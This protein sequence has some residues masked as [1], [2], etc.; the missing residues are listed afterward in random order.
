[1][2][3]KKN[4]DFKKENSIQIIDN[5]R[6]RK[7]PY[8]NA[9]NKIFEQGHEHIEKVSQLP[10]IHWATEYPRILREYIK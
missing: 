1:M 2:Y 8:I 6:E 3:F 4:C 9:C 7:K 10:R 5:S